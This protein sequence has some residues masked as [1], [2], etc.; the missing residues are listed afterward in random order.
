MIVSHTVLMDIPSLRSLFKD[1][2]ATLKSDGRFIFTLLHPCFW[3]QK[4]HLD[5]QTGEWHKEVKGYLE[6][7][8]WRVE[9]FGGHNHYHRPV[10]YYATELHQAGMVIRQLIEPQHE[11][12]GHTEIPEDFTGRHRPRKRIGQQFPLFLVIEAVKHS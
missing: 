6:H 12:T 8:V 5:H 9:D 4:S 7:E 1:V 10:T 2:A 3:N 11:S